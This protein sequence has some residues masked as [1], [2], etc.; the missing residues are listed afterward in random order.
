MLV[1]VDESYHEKDEPNAKSTFT[2]V[3][4]QEER[5]REFDMKLSDLKRHF[6]K[7]AN[8]YDYD[9][10]LKGR[11]LLNSRALTLPKTRDFVE[12]FI[13][14]CKEVDAVF[15]AVVQD[16]TFTLASPLVP[17]YHFNLLR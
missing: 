2:A 1:F 5:Y 15:F 16:G 10:E 7:V 9:M 4:I 12:Q 13:T 11:K 3:A 6:W 14:L 17:E 8:P